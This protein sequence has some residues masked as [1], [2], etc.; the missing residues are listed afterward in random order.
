SAWERALIQR[1]FRGSQP[2][3]HCGEPTFLRY[4][5]SPAVAP[6]QHGRPPRERQFRS[7]PRGSAML[8]VRLLGQFEVRRDG[9]PI[10]LPSR[11]AQ[12][13]LASLALNAGIAHRREKLAG[14]LWPDSDEE[15]ARSNLRHA[16]WRLR[17][18]LEN[19][20]AAGSP[21]LRADD[22]SVAFE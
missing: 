13:L 12:S 18:A 17:R 8:E 10:P 3:Q 5:P 14:L 9:E 7:R 6:A 4:L 22:L 20:A 19:G 2:S 21:H 1:V 15:N 11:A 16:L